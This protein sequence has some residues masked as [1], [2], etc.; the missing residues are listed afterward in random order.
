LKND[1]VPHN[2]KHKEPDP[3]EN[4]ENEGGAL[5]SGAQQPKAPAPNG[6][7]LNGPVVFGKNA[8][9]KIRKHIDQVR[10]RGPLQESIPKPGQ[11]GIDRVKEII[12]DRVAQ[13]GG[14]ATTYAGEQAI[15]FSDGG[16]TYMFRPN[17]EFWTILR[18]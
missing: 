12:R 10:N 3:L 16:V 13:G 15:A 5:S 7:L 14:R 6:A 2:P 4:F 9:E 1:P 8:D 18:N 11:G 17:G